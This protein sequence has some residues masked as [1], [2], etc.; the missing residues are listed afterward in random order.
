MSEMSDLEAEAEATR[1]RLQQTIG[2]IQDKLTVTGMVDEFVARPA[3][4][5]LE[6][7]QD[8]LRGLLNRHPLPVMLA[9]AGIG[10]LIHR[11]GRSRER[12]RTPGEEVAVPALNTGHTRVYDPDVSSRHPLAD[13]AETKR[14]EA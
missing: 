4:A 12:E 13:G 10:F 11:M 5:R 6:G 7:S 2:R 14:V 8:V 1:A 3:V 9:A